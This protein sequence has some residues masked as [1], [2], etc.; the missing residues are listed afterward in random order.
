MHAT[1]P[2]R[3]DGRT[4]ILCYDMNPARNYGFAI[5]HSSENYVRAHST[6]TP[7][8]LYRDSYGMSFMQLKKNSVAHGLHIV[9]TEIS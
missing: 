7:S 8:D 1:Y 6:L 3:T 4:I 2:R 9:A 5:A